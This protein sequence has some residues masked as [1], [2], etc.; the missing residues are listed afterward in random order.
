VDPHAEKYYSIS[1][2]AYCAGNP[3]K[4]IDIDGKD[5]GDFFNSREAA[6]KDFC[7]IYN[8]NSIRSGQEF[9]SRLY[10]IKNAD[11]NKGYTYTSPNIGETGNTAPIPETPI[12]STNAGVVHTH[13]NY[14]YG[15]WDDNSFSGSKDYFGKV[16]N[17]Q[18][19]KEETNIKTDIGISNKEGQPIFVSTPSGSFQKYDPMTGKI[20]ILDKKMPSDSNDPTRMNKN[21]AN[22]ERKP[23]VIPKFPET[24]NPSAPVIKF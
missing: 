18:E 12:G 4:F 3:I 1:P 8:D 15:K 5:P 11:G 13:G 19:N 6:S 17:D 10:T 7:M 23:V 2:Y 21:D 9:G 24:F 22:I 14:S 16:H 20:E